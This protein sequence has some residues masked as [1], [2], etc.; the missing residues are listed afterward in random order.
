MQATVGQA[1]APACEQTGASGV[2]SKRSKF[3]M[4]GEVRLGAWGES[5]TCRALPPPSAA[6]DQFDTSRL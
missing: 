1:T 3:S 5:W 4:V 6:V 2:P